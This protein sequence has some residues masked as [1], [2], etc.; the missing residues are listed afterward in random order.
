M[1]QNPAETA[2]MLPGLEAPTPPALP[3]GQ[4]ELHIRKQTDSLTDLGYLEDHHAGLVHLAIVT[5]QDIDRSQGRGA[6][7]G[8]ANLLRVMNEILESLPQPEAASKD[9]LDL[10]L[11]A[12]R[13]TTAD[14]LEESVMHV[15]ASA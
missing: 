2:P 5:A 1:P 4:L 11:D 14:E 3:V 9:K 13:D 6:P 15:R 7:S 12:L 8:R 10:V